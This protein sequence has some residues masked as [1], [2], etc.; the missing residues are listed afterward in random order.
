MA[1]RV[2]YIGKDTA[3]TTEHI[4]FEHDAFIDGHVV[5]HFHIVAQPGSRHDYHIL[6]QVAALSDYR[7]RHDVAEMP[8][9]GSRP[10]RGTV[11]DVRRF[12]GE[13]IGHVFVRRREE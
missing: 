9:L 12:V 6:A 2:H 13:V 11:I 8:D 7:A 1:T 5:L 3:G 4:V 10:D